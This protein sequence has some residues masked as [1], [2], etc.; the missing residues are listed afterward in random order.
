MPKDVGLEIR[1]LIQRGLD[2]HEHERIHD[3]LSDWETAMRVDPRNVQVKR[4]VEFGRQRVTELEAGEHTSPSRRSTVESPIP[5]FLAALTERRSDKVAIPTG[6]LQD[7]PTA[8]SEVTDRE[9]PE[10][11]WSLLG[12][13]KVPVPGGESPVLRPEARPDSDTL[14]DLPVD[15]ADIRASANELLGE[16]RAALNDNR[17][18]PASLAAELSL[19]LA[20][21]APPPG[22]DDLIDPSRALFERAFRAFMGNPHA[23]PIRA[24][25]TETISEH[26]LDQRAA[27]LMSRMDGMTSMA[28]LIDSSGMPRFDAVRVMASLRRAKAIDVLPPLP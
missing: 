4:L 1:Q 16:C 23:C 11:D 18:G 14:E 10:N 13:A 7:G 21:R 3:A 5:Q 2:H 17:A 25:P 19:Q 28:D 6:P 15:A 20:E 9:T 24:I 12:E 27:F 8:K 22:V 26:G